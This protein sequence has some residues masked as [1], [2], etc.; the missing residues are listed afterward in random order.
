MTVKTGILRGEIFLK[1]LPGDGCPDITKRLEAVYAM[2]DA[3]D[4][5]GRFVDIPSRRA[6]TQEILL[7]H[8]REYFE[9][10]ARI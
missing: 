6:T 4:M 5:Q 3:P 1:H 9:K 8:T 7:F 2:L 10:I